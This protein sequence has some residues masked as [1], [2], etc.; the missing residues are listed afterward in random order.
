MPTKS[1]PITEKQHA[2]RG[3]LVYTYII[4]RKEN[5]KSN[6]VPQTQN[7]IAEA[8]QIFDKGQQRKTKDKENEGNEK[9]PNAISRLWN[10]PPVLTTFRTYLRSHLLRVNLDRSSSDSALSAE[11]GVSVDLYYQVILSSFMS[12]PR[13]S[14][15]LSSIHSPPPPLS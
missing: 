8:L 5:R 4:E 15:S 6:S 2:L 14:N 3:S 7:S 11:L 1:P 10:S 9:E 12:A 13:F